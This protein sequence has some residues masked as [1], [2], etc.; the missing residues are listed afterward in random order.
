[1]HPQSETVIP[2]QR[3]IRDLLLQLPLLVVNVEQEID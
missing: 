1:M 3:P 2:S